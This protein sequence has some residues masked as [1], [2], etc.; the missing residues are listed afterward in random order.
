MIGEELPLQHTV[1][2]SN[3]KNH[4]ESTNRTCNL[5]DR[6]QVVENSSAG[7][8]KNCHKFT[9]SVI[10]IGFHQLTQS[11]F[12]H[13]GWSPGTWS[14]FNVDI[15]ISE[16]LN[17]FCATRSNIVPEAN[18]T[19]TRRVEP[20]TFTP[21]LRSQSRHIQTMNPVIEISSFANQD[22]YITLKA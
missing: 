9:W 5:V 8:A 22:I 21:D 18:T 4:E 14:I 13:L 2:G 19:Q 1:Y 6:A 11:L 16:T 17:Q 10:R 12:T 15:I 3:Q 7:V 20:P